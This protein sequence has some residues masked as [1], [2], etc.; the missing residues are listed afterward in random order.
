MGIRNFL[1]TLKLFL[2][3][4]C[5]LSLWSKL[6]IG[7]R[8]WFLNTN[9]FLSKRS[10]STT[11]FDKV[12][13]NMQNEEDLSNLR[14]RKSGGKIQNLHK[15]INCCWFFPRKLIFTKWVSTDSHLYNRRDQMYIIQGVKGESEKSSSSKF[16]KNQCLYWNQRYLWW[17]PSALEWPLRMTP[18]IWL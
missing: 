8:K 2:I 1:V 16:G 12:K 9:L 17:K 14:H 7:H 15:K 4:K 11:K 5:S 6:A 13:Q 18:R 3:A 10:L